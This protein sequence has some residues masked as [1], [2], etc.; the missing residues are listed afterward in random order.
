MQYHYIV[1][2]ISY[3]AVLYI[4]H[5]LRHAVQELGAALGLYYGYTFARL[6][7]TPYL[8]F[9]WVSEWTYSYGST[10]KVDFCTL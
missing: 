9:W 2:N 1:C 4:Q 3:F 6:D 7:W 8:L 5:M 10:G